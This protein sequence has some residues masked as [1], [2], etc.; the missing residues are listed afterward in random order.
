MT[1]VQVLEVPPGAQL[2]ASSSI[3]RV[4]ML[5]FG[6]NCLSVQGHPEFSA[7]FMHE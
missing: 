4:E 1:H 5:A 7:D 2:L 6:P 3:T